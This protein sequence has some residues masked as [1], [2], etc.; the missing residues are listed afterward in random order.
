[1][2]PDPGEGARLPGGTAHS[3]RILEEETEIWDAWA[4]FR[5][6]YIPAMPRDNDQ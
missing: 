4:P 1:M 6:D 5:E 2:I 3:V